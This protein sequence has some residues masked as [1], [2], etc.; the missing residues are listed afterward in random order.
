M[1]ERSVGNS[2]EP[3]EVVAVRVHAHPNSV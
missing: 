2:L 1:R 3:R